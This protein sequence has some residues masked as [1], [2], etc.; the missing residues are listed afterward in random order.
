MLPKDR[1]ADVAITNSTAVTTELAKVETKPTAEGELSQNYVLV[2]REIVE[3]T[4]KAVE[5]PKE[6]EIIK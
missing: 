6:D 5:V 1:L 4:A 2:S 3:A